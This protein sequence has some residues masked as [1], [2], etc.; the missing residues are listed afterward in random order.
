MVGVSV[1]HAIN[2]QNRVAFGITSI[3]GLAASFNYR[4]RPDIS[5]QTS[6][7]TDLPSWNVLDVA[8]AG[9]IGKPQLGISL[10]IGAI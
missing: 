6:V 4:L 3:R 10:T 7:S 8:K 5:V 9:G 2:P 1:H